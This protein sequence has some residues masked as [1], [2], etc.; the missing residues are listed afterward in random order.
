M[1]MR[2]QRHPSNPGAVG[3]CAQCLRERLLALLAAVSAA[4]G[5]TDPDVKGA[6]HSTSSSSAAS[7][8]S[9]RHLPSPFPKSVSPYISRPVKER[10]HRLFYSTPQLHHP[11][12]SNPKPRKFSILSSIFGPKPQISKVS[13]SETRVSVSESRVSGSSSSST[14]FS[15]LFRK[16]SRLFS[17]ECGGE[18]AAPPIRRRRRRNRGLSPA[19]KGREEEEDFPESTRESGY[20][21]DSMVD[22]AFQGKKVEEVVVSRPRRR[23]APAPP[24]HGSSGFAFCLSPLMRPS[25]KHR[26]GGGGGD[27]VGW[28]MAH[29]G[30]LRNKYL[31][32]SSSSFVNRSRKLADMGRFP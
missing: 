10:D 27:Q 31:C 16:K 24:L 26:Y 25:P 22:S 6:W 4:N 7:G 1:I 5:T 29:S 12:N 13:F 15:S 20:L 14:W 3:V 32:S 17:A 19:E 21:S 8:S 28:D 11:P 9:A 2:C 30:E 23:A 18:V